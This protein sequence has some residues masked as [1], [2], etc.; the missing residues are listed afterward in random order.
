[1]NLLLFIFTIVVSFIVVRIGA[2]A[3]ELTGLEW[4]LAKF[5]ALSCFSSTGFTTKEAELITGHAQ[6][7]KI[8][9]V[10][11]VLGHAGLVTLIATFANTIRPRVSVTEL[12]SFLS[13]PVPAGL[14]PWINLTLLALAGYVIYKILSHA[15]TLGRLTDF[16]RKRVKKSSVVQ[17]ITCQQLMV[18]T[19]GYGVAAITVP[20][21]SR[22]AGQPLRTSG[23]RRRDITLLVLEREK[24][25]MPNPPADTEIAVGDRLV[26]FGKVDIIRQEL[27][28]EA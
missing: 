9:S 13:L 26:C 3:F 22:L 21:G 18:A 24:E 27:A 1:M 15:G 2:I 28:P 11:M 8:A 10:L 14:I 25:T 16:L 12:P 17:P 20:E 5:Q 4:Q 6:R 19:G 23:L 7:R